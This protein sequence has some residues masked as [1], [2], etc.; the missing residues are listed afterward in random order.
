MPAI[1][2]DPTTGYDAATTG[3]VLFEEADGRLTATATV[4]ELGETITITR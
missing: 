2:H 4:A 3:Y 1:P